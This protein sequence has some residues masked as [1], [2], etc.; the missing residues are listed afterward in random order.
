[1]VQ[2]MKIRPLQD[3]V[4]VEL[5][6]PDDHS[7]GGIVLPESSRGRANR[8]IVLA[9][10]QWRNA[11]NNRALIPHEVKIGDKVLFG[12]YAGTEVRRHLGNNLRLV[13]QPEIIAV[14]EETS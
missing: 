3:E 8:G 12:S 1:M 7:E 4:L 9:L 10:G 13:P 11:K 14:L 6:P 2:I 5:L